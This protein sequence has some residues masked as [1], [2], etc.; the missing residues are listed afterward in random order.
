MAS[1]SHGA[2]RTP[3]QAAELLYETMESF[4]PDAELR[5]AIAEARSQNRSSRVTH[6]TRQAKHRIA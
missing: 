3:D 6:G 1:Q 2:R 4:H 5:A